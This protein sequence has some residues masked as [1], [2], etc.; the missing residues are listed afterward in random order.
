MLQ[1]NNLT[2]KTDIQHF[3]RAKPRS[4]ATRTGPPNQNKHLARWL[5]YFSLLLIFT[6]SI[7]MFYHPE[8]AKAETQYVESGQK[9]IDNPKFPKTSARTKMLKTTEG[10]LNAV[11][12]V[13]E[14]YQAAAVNKAKEETAISSTIKT[15]L[16]FG[17]T[18]SKIIDLL[19]KECNLTETQAN[20]KLAQYFAEN[21]TQEDPFRISRNR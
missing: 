12:E 17:A 3:G 7:S 1:Q 6:L 2:T 19:V 20:E 11:C 21:T 16:F 15:A 10:G 8:E 18:E 13:M 9:E 5:G 14:K 4:N